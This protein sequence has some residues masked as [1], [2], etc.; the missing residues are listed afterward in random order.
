[1]SIIAEGFDDDVDVV[2]AGFLDA[3]VLDGGHFGDAPDS[4]HPTLHICCG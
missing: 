1:M 3:D 4:Q 2:E